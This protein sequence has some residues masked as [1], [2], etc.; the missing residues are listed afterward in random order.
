[1]FAY[2]FFLNA[3]CVVTDI[4]ICED[5]PVHKPRQD[6]TPHITVAV[7]FVDALTKRL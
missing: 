7:L 1:M 4:H 2:V 5:G 3:V 6:V